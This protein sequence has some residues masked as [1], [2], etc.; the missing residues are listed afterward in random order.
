MEKKDHL[1]GTAKVQGCQ[2][3]GLD[4]SDAQGIEIKKRMSDIVEE[5]PKQLFPQV[6]HG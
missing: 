1:G 4:N 6:F 5:E 3:K 2:N